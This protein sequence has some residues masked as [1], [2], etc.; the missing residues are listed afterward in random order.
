VPA[1]PTSAFWSGSASAQHTR[2]SRRPWRTFA[3]ASSNP[4]LRPPRSASSRRSQAG[5]V[6]T[7]VG[8]PGGERSTAIQGGKRRFGIDEQRGL[9]AVDRDEG[10]ATLGDDLLHDVAV[11]EQGIRRHDAP[12]Q[13]HRGQQRRRRRQLVPRPDRAH[14]AEHHPGRLHVRRDQLRPRHTV[15]LALAL[16]LAASEHLPIDRDRLTRR[17][18]ALPRRLAARLGLDPRQPGPERGLG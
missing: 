7:P 3:E 8:R 4:R 12:A 5:G 15:R 16:R 14:L 6:V 9:V 11:R 2:T 1:L 18:G 17:R 10:V 13:R